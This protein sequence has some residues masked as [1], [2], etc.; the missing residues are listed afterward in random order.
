MLRLK[1]ST[2][3]KL[4]LLE[5]RELVIENGLIGLIMP[6]PTLNISD[7]SL[8]EIQLPFYLVAWLHF[9]IINRPARLSDAPKMTKLALIE[10]KQVKKNNS[11]KTSLPN[12]LMKLNLF[13]SISLKMTIMLTQS[14]TTFTDTRRSTTIPL[15]NDLN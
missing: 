14:S 5:H 12:S 9:A 2:L 7:I 8:L 3:L 1:F 11:K 6:L 15:F 4:S 10:I 13:L